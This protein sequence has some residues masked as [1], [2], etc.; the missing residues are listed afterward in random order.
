MARVR[1]SSAPN[2]APP[3]FRSPA[4]R[5]A[6]A[7]GRRAPFKVLIA[8]FRAIL[9]WCHL[10]TGITVGIVVFVM[11]VT[12]AALTFQKPMQYWAD[13]SG[14]RVDPPSP[15]ALRLSATELLSRYRQR[16]PDAIV[17]SV[18]WRSGR[19]EPAA[20]AI[21]TRTVYVDPY[22]GA[23]HGEPRGARM[24]AFFTTMTNWHRYMAFAGDTRAFGKG[25]TGACNLGFLFIVLSGMYLWW[26]RTWTWTQFKAVLW[27][28]SGLGPKARH[29]NWHNTIGFW[30]ALPL[31]V[32][33]ASATVI[34]YPWATNLV[35]RLAGEDPPPPAAGRAAGPGPATGRGPNGSS[36]PA[37]DSV[38]ARAT[39][40]DPDWNILTVRLPA[41]A[42]A[43]VTATVDSGDGGQPQLRGTLTLKASGEVTAWEPFSSQSTGRRARSWLRFLHT[44]EALGLPGQTIAGLVSLGGAFLVYTGVSLAIRR[45][46][47]WRPRA[48]PVRR[49]AA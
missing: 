6:A 43:N 35:Y 17:T 18:T 12:G 24:R 4:A 47:G 39:E 11:S 36:S 44:G 27:F 21:G 38:V 7:R 22:S 15:D 8:Q 45:L 25:L 28:R 3:S 14:Y 10:V 1:G 34:S 23:V 49:R 48:R 42:G 33:V 40:L 5:P 31:A 41:N 26:P 16:E 19:R 30:S 29:F 46:L 13:A 37:L 9:F 20:L 2:S 32:V